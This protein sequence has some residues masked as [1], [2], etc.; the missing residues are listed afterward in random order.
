LLEPGGLGA[1]DPER[2]AE[3]LGDPAIKKAYLG[4]A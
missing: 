1:R 3:L 4:V 2:S